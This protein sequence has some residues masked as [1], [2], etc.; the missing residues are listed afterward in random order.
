MGSGLYIWKIKNRTLIILLLLLF[1]G[2]KEPQKQESLRAIPNQNKIENG[3]IVCRLGNGYFSKHFKKFAS[4]EMIYSHIGIVSKENNDIYVYHSEASE[5]SGV[6]HVK[7]ETISSFLEDIEIYDFFQLKYP[8][9]TKI[10]IINKV[11][12]Y[13]SKKT[14]F[15]LN[16]DSYNDNEVYCTEL[17][18]ISINKALKKEVI[19]PTLSVYGKKLYAL[20]DIYLNENIKKVEL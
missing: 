10:K 15:D 2:C 7:K 4:Q 11:K 20:D 12:T 17:I 1:L 9:S 19:K 13:Y 14:P 16:F 5:L 3:Y 18:A 8:D 6:G